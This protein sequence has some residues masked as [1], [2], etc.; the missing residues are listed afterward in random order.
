MAP[1][2]LC[3]Y[4][5]GLA[6]LFLAQSAAFAQ[7]RIYWTDA[8]S[9]SP[10][11]RAT[12]IDGSGINGSS[13][14]ALIPLTIGSSPFGIVI[15]DQA[16]QIFWADKIA[17]VIYRAD[18]NG[19]GATPFINSQP[20]VEHLALD[21][22]NRV[23]YWSFSGTNIGRQALSGSTPEL[24]HSSMSLI[25]GL[26]V[27]PESSRIF[28]VENQDPTTIFTSI[29]LT[30]A[31][32]QPIGTISEVSG[33]AVDYRGRIFWAEQSVSIGGLLSLAYSGA[34]FL[35]IIPALP[36]TNPSAFSGIA[37]N[38]QASNVFF[39]NTNDQAIY[40]SSLKPADASPQ[41]LLSTNV[42]RIRGI[43]LSCGKF[44]PDTD[45]DGH[46]DCADSCLNDP[47]KTEAGICGCGVSDSDSDGDGLIAC[48]EEC[49]GDPN[50]IEA[51]KCG[52]GVPETDS[53]RDG[54]PDCNDS[55]PNDVRKVSPGA[56]GCGLIEEVNN[57]GEQQC[58][59]NRRLAPNIKIETP[60][61]ITIEDN[62]VTI[63]LERFKNP[64]LNLKKFLRARSSKLGILAATG[65]SKLRVK[66]EV[67]IN[68]AGRKRQN[69]KRL[70]AKRNELTVKNLG[71]G[72]YNVKYKAVITSNG[73]QVAS[74]SFSP[75]ASFTIR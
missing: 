55:C 51:G 53:D 36:S 72:N 66:Y 14:T 25:S 18:L 2:K 34:D 60:P 50:K 43:A 13:S 19:S 37:I 48:N 42:G 75:K 57:A 38:R 40:H 68:P 39:G 1:R 63:I 7:E 12:E 59:E 65:K 9:G 67:V 70:T 52:C 31:S 64:T 23:L 10:H 27:D 71:A 26:A 22:S 62:E 5:F 11:I 56:C 17:G 41:V 47:L 35:S 20:G 4:L 69:F 44:A 61:I 54:T 24:Y 32:P 45:S 30:T 33:I 73:S 28:W 29:S 3:L 49:D 21:P 58:V 8:S 15:D 74:T 16:G 6:A 46:P